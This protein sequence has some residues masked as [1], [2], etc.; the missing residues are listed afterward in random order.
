MT[1]TERNK[2]R[3]RA[4]VMRWRTALFRSSAPSSVKL[5]LLALAE[6]AN[7]DGTQCFPSV[8]TLAADTGQNE[9]TCRRALDAADG[10]WFTRTPI[11]LKGR[12]WRGY[13][14]TLS[15]PEGADTV[16]G[17]PEQGADMVPGPDASRSGH[18]G[19]EVR[20]FEPQGAGTVSD[21]LVE[22]PSKS[23]KEEAPAADAAVPR[24]RVA[25]KMTLRAWF[26]S[27]PQGERGV[28]ETD[29]IFDYAEKI[30]LPYD[31]LVLQWKFF[32]TKYN[33]VPKTYTDWR[34]VFRNSVRSNWFK[35]WFLDEAGQY[36]L[37]TQ[38]RQ[39][40]REFGMSVAA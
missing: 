32:C 21:D 30:D 17:T 8:E 37:T 10:T 4:L 31:F 12:S 13:N 36:L 40:E 33:D 15:M 6:H 24:K 18:S 20:T 9:K 28:P 14:Y 22:A 39:A 5:T 19:V 1:E 29:P 2:P 38:G 25:K 27:L 23:T 11:K 7:P 3:K 35:L 16:S 26:D 34:A